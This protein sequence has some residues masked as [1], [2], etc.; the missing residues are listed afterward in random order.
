MPTGVT[1]PLSHGEWNQ[2][3][4]TPSRPGWEP[5]EHAALLLGRPSWVSLAPTANQSSPGF[6]GHIHPSLLL[7]GLDDDSQGSRPWPCG[8]E[9]CVQTWLLHFPAVWPWTGYFISLSLTSFT[10]K[11]RTITLGER[12]VRS[13]Y[14]VSCLL[15][16][17]SIRVNCISCWWWQHLSVSPLL[18][19]FSP[20]SDHCFLFLTP[21][22]SFNKLNSSFPS[23]CSLTS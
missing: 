16:V 3:V 23:S 7:A 8:E 9:N 15:L 1:G 4:N 20:D 17:G 13:R 11:M 14:L 12:E 10:C 21:E 5:V 22:L 18:A 19:T 2:Q 6:W